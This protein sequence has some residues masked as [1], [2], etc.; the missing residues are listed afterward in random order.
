VLFL[1]FIITI[2]FVLC[3]NDGYQNTIPQKI[4]LQFEKTWHFQP[5]RKYFEITVD[6]N[7]NYFE[8]TKD[9]SNIIDFK[10][11]SALRAESSIVNSVITSIGQKGELVEIVDISP[12]KAWAF[13][14]CRVTD[15]NISWA[16]IPYLYALYL[17]DLKNSEVLKEIPDVL[18]KAYFTEDSNSCLYSELLEIKQMNI[19]SHETAMI[20]ESKAFFLIPKRDKIINFD[21]GKIYFYVLETGEQQPIRKY[22]DLISEAGLIS[23]KWAYLITYKSPKRGHYSLY[24]FNLENHELIKYPHKFYSSSLI[25]V[26]PVKDFDKKAEIER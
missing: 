8:E 10:E 13:V 17:V 14:K 1:A 6:P 11:Y 24:F 18:C 9:I 20:C 21:K 25:R 12:S 5:E 19:M 7:K 2:S 3:K 15:P 4:L 26:V 16:T 23:E 22:P